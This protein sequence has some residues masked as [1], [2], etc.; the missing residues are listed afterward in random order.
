M[1]VYMLEGLWKPE[2]DGGF[3]GA[4]VP[5][6]CEPLDVDTGITIPDLMISQQAL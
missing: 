6:V 5:G 2:K 3:L 1:C 4:G